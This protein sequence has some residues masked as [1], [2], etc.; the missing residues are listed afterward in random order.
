MSSPKRLVCGIYSEF[1]SHNA[2]IGND[3]RVIVQ[4][5]QN[6]DVHIVW[7][8]NEPKKLKRLLR[9]FRVLVFGPDTINGVD[10][11]YSPHVLPRLFD[12]PHLLR[13]HDI[14]P[15]TNP[16]WF[17]FLSRVFFR[18]SLKTHKSS[19]LL[20]DSHTSKGAFQEY[21]GQPDSTHNQVL[22][23]K[24]RALNV[25]QYCK[26][27]GACDLINQIRLGNFALAVGTIEPR[28]NYK[29][30][31][32]SWP[33][34][35][36]ELEKKLPLFVVGAN[37]WK[38]NKIKKRLKKRRNDVMWLGEVCD[39][40]LN[41]LYSNAK[42][43]ISASEAEGFN[44]PI[45]EALSY[46][47]P[48]VASLIDVHIEI[49]E[50]RAIFFDLNSVESLCIAVEQALTANKLMSTQGLNANKLV[51]DRNVLKSAISEVMKI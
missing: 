45:E 35:I 11:I 17:K 40:S 30:L 4:E 2:G 19:Y 8:E 6:L 18:L 39:S 41:D 38:T 51:D 15:L 23:C 26:S 1:I 33:V 29:F 42:I 48:A 9:L 43:F 34:V 47:I 46:G 13:V 20:F 50:N 49:Y 22:Y 7:L 3:L 25:N 10:F 36:D 5:I 16:E 28:K 14:F 44:L 21:F 27:C 37:G 31:L 24:I 12:A 32:N